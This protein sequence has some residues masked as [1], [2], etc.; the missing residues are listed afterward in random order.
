MQQ[1]NQADNC[2]TGAWPPVVRFAP[3]PNGYLHLG[4]AYSAWKNYDFARRNG[5]RFL[6]RIEDIDIGRARPEFEAAIFEDLAWLGIEW[7]RPVRRQSDHFSDYAMAL[8]KLAQNALI[9]PCTCSR[10][11]IKA[12]VKDNP[13]WPRD[14]DGSPLYPGTCREPTARRGQILSGKPVAQRIDMSAAIGMLQG[15]LGW[16]EFGE[17]TSSRFVSAQPSAWGDAVIGRKDV[18]GS[19]HIA[20]VVDDAL[21]GVTDVIRGMDLFESTSLHRLLQEWLDLP[22]PNY[23]HHKLIEDEAGRKLSKSIGSVSLRELR[24]QGV[25]PDQIRRRLGL[26]E[27]TMPSGLV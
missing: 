17:A 10:G 9:Y 25:T 22:A 16:C 14:P 12:A 7:E 2:G 20:V 3:S 6:L 4:H 23:R 18:P 26:N 8:E 13:N 27:V 15:P 1:A 24:A 21:Q 11:D 19:Y 5:G